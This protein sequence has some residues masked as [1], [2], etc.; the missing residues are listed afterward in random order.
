MRDRKPDQQMS[1]P[2]SA[3]KSGEQS[4][5]SKQSD[6]RNNVFDLRAHQIDLHGR[7]VLKRVIREGYIKPK[8]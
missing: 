8:S 7:A 1:F 4:I 2:F 6:S 3:S 5:K